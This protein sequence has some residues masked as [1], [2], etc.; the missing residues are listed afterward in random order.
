MILGCPKPYRDCSLIALIEQ[1]FTFTP[2]KYQVRN[3]CYS[4]D[5]DAVYLDGTDEPREFEMEDYSS[6]RI[7]VIGLNR[8]SKLGQHRFFTANG[9][10]CPD[11][12]YT[13][14]DQKYAL[15]SLLAGVDDETQMIVKSMFG[16]RGLE[17]FL[18][19]KGALIKSADGD[20]VASEVSFQRS[21]KETKARKSIID[22]DPEPRDNGD[23]KEKAVLGGG[24]DDEGRY[25]RDF[26]NKPPITW[27]ITSRVFLKN[28]YRVL[29]FADGTN[30]YCER[31]VNLDHFQNNLAVGSKVTYYGTDVSKI[32][33]VAEIEKYANILRKA[34]PNA[35]AMSMDA[36][37]DTEGN[38]GMFE[39]SGEFGFKAINLD[40][41]RKA[42]VASIHKIVEGK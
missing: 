4:T 5:A 34:F 16:A 9:I 10:I 39:F 37:V 24:R 20:V 28:E 19:K 41:L 25:S 30:L 14:S 29:V 11:W 2:L 42:T 23:E 8:I 1:D 3:G 7:P 31:H 17:Q 40:D 22:I 38:V 35:F 12:F 21:T 13:R 6:L 18:I 27:L 26:F 33:F 32:S 15:A 36:Y